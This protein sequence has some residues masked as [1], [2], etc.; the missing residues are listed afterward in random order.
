MKVIVSIFCAVFVLYYC[1][2]NPSGLLCTPVNFEIREF[3]GKQY[4][5]SNDSAKYICVEFDKNA[6]LLE[7]EHSCP[8]TKSWWDQTYPVLVPN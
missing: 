4:K 2:P 1:L 6:I 5:C 8:N 3:V 7:S